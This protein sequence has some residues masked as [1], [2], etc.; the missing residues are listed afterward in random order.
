[1]T[2]FCVMTFFCPNS[3]A[4]NKQ[5]HTKCKKV[6]R[7]SELNQGPAGLQP[8]ALPLSYI[9]RYETVGKHVYTNRC[10]GVKKVIC[11]KW[12]LNPRPHTRTRILILHSLSRGQGLNLES[13][14]LDHSAILTVRKSEG[15]T[16]QKDLYHPIWGSNP[17]PLD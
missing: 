2:F 14:A 3:Q 13:G 7:H 10:A 11:Q 4:N 16:Q 1:M 9:S 8:D 17:G 6:R 12:D 5:N 15:E